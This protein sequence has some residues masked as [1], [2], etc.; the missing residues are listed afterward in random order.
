LHVTENQGGSYPGGAINVRDLELYGPVAPSAPSAPTEY[1]ATT[2]SVTLNIPALQDPSDTLAIYGCAHGGT[3][4]LI[5]DVT[6]QAGST[7]TATSLAAL[8]EYDF[9]LIETNGAGDS[10]M[11][12]LLNA[13]TIPTAPSGLHVAS[14]SPG[15][16]N[17]AW[18]AESG[19]TGY[20]VYRRNHGSGG[21]TEIA[22]NVASST[23]AD[24]V[25][26]GQAYDYYVT[27]LDAQGES[28]GSNVLT[29]AVTYA[30]PGAAPAYTDGDVA[31]T[32][33]SISGVAPD[34]ATGATGTLSYAIQYSL[35]AG[36]TWSAV[37]GASALSVG[38]S[39]LLS[40]LSNDAAVVLR[41]VST[42]AAGSTNGT[43]SAG[44]VLPPPPPPAAASIIGGKAW[45]IIPVGHD[46][47]SIA[48]PGRVTWEILLIG[49]VVASSAAPN[50]WDCAYAG[51][52]MAVRPPLEA[53]VSDAYEARYDGG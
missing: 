15:T 28:A 35:D 13:W 19:A 29:G 24:A 39:W 4:A 40:G 49:A 33:S 31:K 44:L 53:Q 37:P 27:A 2:T 14:S 34:I 5:A 51:Q 26:N 41:V 9:G 1:S 45:A 43:A 6:A 20:N 36:A 7:Y 46:A 32:Y 21:Y 12:A 8:S 52:T 42:G 11:S 48:T 18:N 3:P 25:T 38:G 50:G 17:L 22:S 47:P 30:L 10:P 23:Y 16:I